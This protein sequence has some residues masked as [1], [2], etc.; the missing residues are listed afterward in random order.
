M[1]RWL[2]AILWA[3]L[4]TI[5]MFG[6]FVVWTMSGVPL[7]MEI[8]IRLQLA[9][10]GIWTF[11]MIYDVWSSSKKKPDPTFTEAPRVE[12]KTG[13]LLYVNDVLYRFTE[14]S[15]PMEFDGTSSRIILESVGTG[16]GGIRT[17]RVT[18]PE[19]FKGP[20]VTPRDQDP[21]F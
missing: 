1:K 8:I 17:V 13:A 14:M 7:W 9:M 21:D 4:L 11:F 16:R 10:W 3:F 2:L 6:M 15:S 5:G 12:V 20:M 19:E 18:P